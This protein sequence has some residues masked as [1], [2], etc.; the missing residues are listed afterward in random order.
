MGMYDEI[1]CEY[2]R[3]RFDCGELDRRVPQRPEPG[4]LRMWLAR[5][6]FGSAIRYCER[7]AQRYTLRCL[8]RDAWW[9]SE[10][11]RTMD[12]IHGLAEW[13]DVAEVRAAWRRSARAIRETQPQPEESK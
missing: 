1:V 5:L 2:A 13:R 3:S 11:P 10:C 7:E 6:L 9:F 8:H 12:A 4:R